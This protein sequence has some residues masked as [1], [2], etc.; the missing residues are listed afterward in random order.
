VAE[1]RGGVAQVEAAGQ[2]PRVR[3]L[4]DHCGD[5]FRRGGRDGRRVVVG[6]LADMVGLRSVHSQRCAAAK[7]P[8]KMPWMPLIMLAFIG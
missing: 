7:A 5:V 1:P 2:E 3:G 4:G 8:D 6:G